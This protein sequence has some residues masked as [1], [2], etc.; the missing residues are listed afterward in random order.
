MP[1]ANALL[2]IDESSVCAKDEAQYWRIA[3]KVF[4]AGYDVELRWTKDGQEA[5]CC[6]LAK[7][8]EMD[9]IICCGDREVFGE[10]IAAVPP[11]HPAM[12]VYH[13]PCNAVAGLSRMPKFFFQIMSWLRSFAVCGTP[14]MQPAF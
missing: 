14:P 1:R 10:G 6:M 2:V 3:D 7:A 8:A 5:R 4:H 9:I 13:V 11:I 12:T